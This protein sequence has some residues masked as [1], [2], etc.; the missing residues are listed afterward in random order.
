MLCHVRRALLAMTLAILPLQAG[1]E[2]FTWNF[3]G[4][5]PKDATVHQLSR[6]QIT[7]EGLVI[8]TQTDGYIIWEDSP[9]TGP[10]DV[11]TIRART[12]R[13]VEAALLW[14]EPGHP[15]NLIQLP[16]VIPEGKDTQEIDV[17]VRNYRE[18]DWRAQRFGIGFPKGTNVLIEEMQFRH[19]SA[20]EKLVEAW[21]TFW[22]FD[23][24]RPY[25]INFLWGPLI[26]T[27][28]VSRAELFDTLPPR[29][30]S[31]VWI[32]YG[33][34]VLSGVAALFLHFGKEN[35]ALRN[36]WGLLGIVWT[37]GTCWTL[38]DLRMGVELLSY[39]IED[40]RSFVLAPIEEQSLRTH[41][42][43]YAI[44][45]EITP[46]L[47]RA[48]RY[49]ILASEGAPYY[50]NLRYM[51]YPSIPVREGEDT[52]DVRLWFVMERP[53]VT[54]DSNGRLRKGAEVLTGTGRILR[55]FDDIAF[56]FE[57][58]P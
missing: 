8:D 44:A 19:W 55:A 34:I 49:G 47:M 58:L 22:T 20:S 52:S 17:T 1:A 24:F 27:N 43:F 54:V 2:D 35:R 32:F 41:G 15:D 56:L 7:R 23:T 33:L 30:H 16:F 25:S 26:A 29:A 18:W 53:D 40:L 13:A 38:F 42:P 3:R 10:A 11:I 48:G 37:F 12:T 5:L 57:V 45:Q 51:T 14:P 31:A 46:D 9:L 21:K 39:A 50:A 6:A 36:A 28:P 4:E